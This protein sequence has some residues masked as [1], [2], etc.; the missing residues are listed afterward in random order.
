MPAIT[1]E[2][3][4]PSSGPCSGPVV[5]TSISVYLS[6]RL[7]CPDPLPP[8][9]VTSKLLE[10]PGK[11]EG[12]RAFDQPSLSDWKVAAVIPALPFLY[13]LEPGQK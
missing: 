6:L 7:E 4:V 3:W 10:R 1:V 11:L 5:I 8:R 13:E 12:C 2:P 9:E